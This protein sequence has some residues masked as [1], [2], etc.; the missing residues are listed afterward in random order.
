MFYALST[1]QDFLKDRV[2][3]FVAFAPVLRIGSNAPNYLKI[4]TNA[5]PLVSATV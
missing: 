2:N 3:L 4:I 1:N 5:L